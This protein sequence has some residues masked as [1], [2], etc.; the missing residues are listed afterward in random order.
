MTP[1]V[2]I[3]AGLVCTDIEDGPSL[4]TQHTY[5]KRTET[6]SKAAIAAIADAAIENRRS[7]PEPSSEEDYYTCYKQAVLKLP[8]AE[9]LKLLS[10]LER[11][12]KVTISTVD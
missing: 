6:L 3:R 4:P 2:A 12:N 10:E 1:R 9:K 11:E 8:L 5:S 7:D